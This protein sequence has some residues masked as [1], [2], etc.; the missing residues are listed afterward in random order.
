MME[1]TI[2]D[3]GGIQ[4]RLLIRCLVASLAHTNQISANA[5]LLILLVY[6][7]TRNMLGSQPVVGTLVRLPG[8][9]VTKLRELDR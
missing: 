4:C 7:N 8:A 9:R 6:A 1:H 2:E 5:T 3:E